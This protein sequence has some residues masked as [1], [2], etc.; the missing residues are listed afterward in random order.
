MTANVVCA[1]IY[2]N[3]NFFSDEEENKGITLRVGH[4]EQEYQEFLDQLDFTY[5]DGYGGQELYG[6]VWLTDGI[7]L[8]RGEYDGSEWW[9][10]NQYPEIPDELNTDARLSAFETTLGQAE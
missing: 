4:T 6:K 8:D 10:I 5:D 1:Q 3:P 7:W 9:N 2:Y